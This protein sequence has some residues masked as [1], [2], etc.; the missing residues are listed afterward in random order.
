MLLCMIGAICH[1]RARRDAAL[2]FVPDRPSTVPRF[3]QDRILR[4]RRGAG[5]VAAAAAGVIIATSA[6]MAHTMIRPRLRPGHIV[7][8]VTFIAAGILRL[9][10]L[11]VM[12]VLVPISIAWAWWER[13]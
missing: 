4:F 13:R 11:W 8:V 3:R 2:R 12:A 6:H 7:A 10:L 9:P 1:V 5:M